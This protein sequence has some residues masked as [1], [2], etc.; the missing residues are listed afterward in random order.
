MTRPNRGKSLSA[1]RL[2]VAKR[3]RAGHHFGNEASGY[4]AECQAPMRVTECQPNSALPRRAR[5]HRPRV[6]KAWSR[7]QPRVRLDAFTERKH[8]ASCRQHAVELDRR[9]LSVPRREFHASSEAD[10]LLHRRQNVTV[11]GVEHRTGERGALLGAK[12][13]VVAALDGKRQFD[14]EP[15]ENIRRPGAEREHRISGIDRSGIRL[16]PPIRPCP[17]QRARIAR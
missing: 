13:T 11:L 16:Y 8:F 7:A 12:V 15:I 2:R 17:M 4:R 3:R 5:N 10:A 6:G 9:R 1:I 14:A